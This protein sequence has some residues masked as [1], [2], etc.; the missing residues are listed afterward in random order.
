MTWGVCSQSVACKF[1][2]LAPGSAGRSGVI[3]LISEH[4]SRATYMGLKCFQFYLL[5]IYS[6][7]NAVPWQLLPSGRS[8]WFVNKQKIRLD[9]LLYPSNTS[10]DHG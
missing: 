2:D 8:L 7:S 4:I 1:S 10:S 9:T 6:N 5:C 3:E